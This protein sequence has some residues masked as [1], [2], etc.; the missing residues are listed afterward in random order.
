MQVRGILAGSASENKKW[1]P[2]GLPFGAGRDGVRPGGG[3]AL[4]GPAWRISKF[5]KRVGSPW[6]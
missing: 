2:E 6:A 1:S 5:Q 4:A 3:G